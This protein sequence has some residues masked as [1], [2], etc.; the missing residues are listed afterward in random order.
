[1]VFNILSGNVDD[2]NKNISFLM[3]DFGKWSLAPAYDI[4]YCLDSNSSKLYNRHELTI[5]G[6]AY[7]ITTNDL[8]TIGEKN[9]IRNCSQIIDEIKETI[10]N[11]DLYAKKVEIPNN[12]LYTIK[13]T[14]NLQ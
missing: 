2:H 7:D 3:D 14:I 10:S 11:I 9:D 13:N 5:Q 12:I 1:M 6:K 4:T 8:L